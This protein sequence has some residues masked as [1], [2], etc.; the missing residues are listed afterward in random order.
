MVTVEDRARLCPVCGMPL[1]DPNARAMRDHTDDDCVA[2]RARVEAE[3]D[4][5]GRH[6]RHGN[7]LQERW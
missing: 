4:K 2:E 3:F 7:V 5:V 1:Y 6:R